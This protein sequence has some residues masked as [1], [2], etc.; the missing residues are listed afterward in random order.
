MLPVYLQVVLGLDAFETGMR[1]FP[2][3]V[4]MFIA[5][6]AG[7]ALAARFARSAVAQP[8]SWRSPSPRCSSS[9]TI[10][11]ELNDAGF[12]IA[13]ARVRH[14]GRACCCRSSAT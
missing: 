1:L 14:R 12:A 8:A 11:V 7:A 6:L 4:A 13:L 10:D 9:A 3:S 2:M 5:A